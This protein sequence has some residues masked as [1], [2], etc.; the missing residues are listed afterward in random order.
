[1]P[2]TASFWAILVSPQRENPS[3]VRRHLT[4]RHPWWEERF[5]AP[6]VQR[7]QEGTAVMEHTVKSLMQVLRFMA[8]ANLMVLLGLLHI[9]KAQATKQHNSLWFSK[10]SNPDYNGHPLIDPYK[11]LE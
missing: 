11:S 9:Y 6:A 1:M 2:H 3:P 10:G 7:L 8:A 4:I 5:Q